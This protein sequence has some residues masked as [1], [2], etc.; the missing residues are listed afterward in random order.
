LYSEGNAY[1]LALRNDRY[2]VDELHLMNPN[3]C[4]P[5]LATTGDI[6]YQLQGNDVIARRL[7]TDQKLYVPM[8]DVLHVRLNTN[9]RNPVPLIG[10]SPIMAA[11]DDI[12]VGMAI[13]K[14]QM[15]F[16][17]NEA[18]PSAVLSTDLILDKEQVAQLRDRWNEQAKGL[19]QG[20]TPI[21][22]AG[23]K[24][25]PWAMGGKDAAIAD[26]A[27]MSKENIALVYRVPLAILG[28]G[29]TTF[30]STE[31]LM[32]A[33]IATGLGF[34]LNHVEESFDQL[35][36]MD[37]Q[38]DEYVEFST[39]PLL[40]SQFKDRIETMAKAVVG[41][42]F[43]PNEA[44]NAEGLDNV[45]FGDEPRVQQQVVPL[46]QVGET[47]P[48]PAPN[49]P[50]APPSAPPQPQPQAKP[51]PPAPKGNSDEFNREVRRLFAATERVARRRISS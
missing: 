35:F 16:Y 51:K 34:A 28:L 10:Q 33:W 6:F 50:P 18:R 14:Q 44:R 32:Q 11:M 37:G 40:R 38:P 2:E 47:P 3:L 31:L 20:G 21:L 22:T 4:L 26:I 29:N 25:Q 1:A 12:G 13:A 30:A 46:S 15:A 9:R 19:K 17:M 8:R 45:P 49:A 48:A 5:M 23:L 43:S 27:K 39:E 41:G 36:N 7:G 24:V 42:I